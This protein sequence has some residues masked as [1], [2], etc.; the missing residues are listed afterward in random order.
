MGDAP[1][2]SSSLPDTSTCLPAHG[3]PPKTS[4]GS[5]QLAS[6]R[7]WEIP[8]QPHGWGNKGN[9]PCSWNLRFQ[10]NPRKDFETK[11]DLPRAGIVPFALPQWGIGSWWGEGWVFFFVLSYLLISQWPLYHSAIQ[12]EGKEA[13]ITLA[14]VTR[15]LRT[16][17]APLVCPITQLCPSI[18]SNKWHRGHSIGVGVPVSRGLFY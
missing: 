17:L 16:E 6:V 15:P 8:P 5:S 10:L 7:S 1:G 13:K 2:P 14:G 4:S 18:G 3:I 9:R 11:Q 12:T